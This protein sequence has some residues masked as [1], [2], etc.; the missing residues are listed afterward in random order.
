MLS[1]TGIPN[2]PQSMLLGFNVVLLFQIIP[3]NYANENWR[4]DHLAGNHAT[5]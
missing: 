1:T 5:I 2:E 4:I 3:K